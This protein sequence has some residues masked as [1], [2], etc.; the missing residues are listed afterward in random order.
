VVVVISITTMPMMM[1][2]GMT[3]SDFFS[4]TKRAA[5]TAPRGNTH[6]DDT[7]QD[8]GL[9]QRHVQRLFRPF[10]NDELQCRPGTPEERGHGQRNLAELVFP[11]GGEAAGEIDDET[12]GIA[13]LVLVAGTGI[14]NVEV[15][16]GGD[17]VDAGDDAQGRFGGGVNGQV[18]HREVEAEDHR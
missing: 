7:L 6:G 10:Q 18:D 13:F 5:A 11:Q 1:P 8:G 3:V 14:R 2:S 9:V 12:D 16:E 15:E 17:D 4:G